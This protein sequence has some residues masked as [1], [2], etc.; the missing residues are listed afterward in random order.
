MTE[1]RYR[2]LVRPDR[3]LLSGLVGTEIA[4]SRSPSIHER[5]A[6]AHGLRLT[7]AL[8]DLA[9]SPDRLADVIRSASELGFAGLNVTHPFKQRV[10]PLLDG[11]NEEAST[12]GAVNTVAFGPDGAIGYNT[13]CSGFADGL[14]RRLPN[15]DLSSV[16]QLGA[17]GAGSA[18]AYAILAAGAERLVIVDSESNRA[19]ALAEHLASIF[20]NQRIICCR[21]ADDAVEATGIVNATPVGM[22]GHP[23][24]PIDI[25]LLKP[26]HWVADVVYF[27]RETE[28]LRA[29]Q[30]IGCK[31]VDGSAMVVFQAA[32]AFEIFTGL[33]ADRERMLTAFNEPDDR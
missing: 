14:R 19:R 5:E 4:A 1:N 8:F 32:R 11:L 7:Y 33:K 28:L 10:I 3:L 25:A 21:S 22:H 12:I 20:S 26:S 30:A 16:L 29:A 31:T 23:G 17:G 9:S 2:R 13:D 6:Q 24:T 27:P 15:A 18:T